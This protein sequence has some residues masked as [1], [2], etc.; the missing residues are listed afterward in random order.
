VAGQPIDQVRRE[1][2][3]RVERAFDQGLFGEAA[4]ERTDLGTVINGSVTGPATGAVAQLVS[5]KTGS[6]SVT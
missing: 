1:D 4:V 6:R 3:G 5:A 2:D